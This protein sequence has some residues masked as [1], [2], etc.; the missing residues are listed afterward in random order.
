MC[1]SDIF[2]TENSCLTLQNYDQAK[3]SENTSQICCVTEKHVNTLKL[4][5]KF[6]LS[7][8]EIK[9]KSKYH[10]NANLTENVF[11]IYFYGVFQNTVEDSE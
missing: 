7:G 11:Y 10:L 2:C 8:R 6:L 4:A 1:T 3:A 5:S 9:L